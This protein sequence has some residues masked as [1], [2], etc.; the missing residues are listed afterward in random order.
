MKSLA[1]EFVSVV[2]LKGTVSHALEEEGNQSSV[3]YDRLLRTEGDDD[4]D[5][6]EEANLFNATSL[7]GCCFVQLCCVM[8]RESSIVSDVDRTEHSNPNDS[9][10][11][12]RRV[13]DRNCFSL[14]GCIIMQQ[15]FSC[16]R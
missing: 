11:R 14:F 13:S 1:A 8:T 7:P 4:D 6:E 3:F 16:I 10:I 15:V 12:E 9:D 5:E 2:Q